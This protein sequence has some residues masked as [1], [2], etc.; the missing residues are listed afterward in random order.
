MCVCMYVCVYERKRA[1]VYTFI[2]IYLWVYISVHKCGMRVNVCVC[3]R[4]YYV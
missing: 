4:E 2:R 3:V 1:C